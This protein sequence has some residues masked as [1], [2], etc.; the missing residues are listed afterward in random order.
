MKLISCHID[1]FGTF[2]DFDL[3]FE[4]DLNVI[5][6][7]NGWGKST[8]AAFLI[9]M[10]YGFG[11]NRKQSLKE[12]DRKH[13]LPWQG[14]KYGGTL[15]F[16]KEGKPYLLSRTFG[17]TKAGDAMCLQE[18]DT[19]R[20][21]PVENVGEWLFALDEK[22]FRR[23][24]FLGQ[25]GTPIEGAD[26][27]IHN[28]LN[29]IL[30]DSQDVRAYDA[31]MDALKERSKE[32]EKR[33]QRG[34]L[35]EL[36]GKLEEILQQ[37]KEEEA[38][39]QKVEEA[40]RSIADNKKSL[41][42]LQEEIDALK[43][44][45][46]AKEGKKK[47]AEATLKLYQE[48]TKQKKDVM[49]EL[50]TFLQKHSLP[51]EEEVQDLKEA[52]TKRKQV[53]EELLAQKE[54]R[55][56]ELLGIRKQYEELL[57][58]KKA[59]EDEERELLSFGAIPTETELLSLQESFSQQK[60]LLETLASLAKEQ[61]AKQEAL[62]LQYQGLRKEQ[63]R[64]QQEAVAASSY[65]SVELPD[66][67]KLQAIRHEC[68]EYEQLSW[69][70]EELQAK[71]KDFPASLPDASHLQH[72]QEKLSRA[73]SLSQ[74]ASGIEK[75]IAGEREEEKSLLRAIQQLDTME[76]TFPIATPAS[77]NGLAFACF[78]LG[79]LAAV[80]G[81][82]LSPLLFVATAFLFGIGLS[83]FT[84]SRK[85][86]KAFAEKKQ[87]F[88]EEKRRVEA[89]K[90][91][92]KQRQTQLAASLQQKEEE[93]KKVKHLAE[94]LRK[95]ALGELATWSPAVTEETAAAECSAL[96]EK[97]DRLASYDEQLSQLRQRKAQREQTIQSFLASYSL[98]F[99]QAKR[100]LADLE[101][102]IENASRAKQA[103]ELQNQRVLDFTGANPTLLAEGET[104]YETPAMSTIKQ[105]E[106]ECEQSI[107]D[108]LLRY[109]VKEDASSLA[110]WM[111]Q[112]KKR[113]LRQRELQEKQEQ[114]R[115]ECKA[116][117][118]EYPEL[119]DKEE[120]N[121]P[122]AVS[123]L[124][125]Q[126][127][128]LNERIQSIQTRYFIEEE[129]LET[130]ML[131][132]QTR[133]NEL[134]ELQQKK[135]AILAQVEDFEREHKAL[136]DL[137]T[138]KQDTS[139]SLQQDLKICEKRKEA[140]QKE[141][142]QA[143]S[144]ITHSDAHLQSYR[145][146]ILQ[147]KYCERELQK[148]KKSLFILKQTQAF[149]EQAKEALTSRYMGQMEANF[150][151]YLLAWLKN[152]QL[153]AFLDSKFSVKLEEDGKEHVVEG[154]SSGY[155]DMIDFCMRMALVDSL[156]EKE[157]PF[158]IMDDPFVN[159]DEEH[160]EYALRFLKGLAADSQILYFVCHPI[161]AHEP[162]EGEISIDRKQL[163]K[164][165][166]KQ[167]ETGKQAPKKEK[168]LLKP[169]LALKVL[170]SKNRITNN[171]FS[172]EFAPDSE[173]VGAAEFELFFVDEKERV[174]CDKQ[175]VTV[176]SGEVFPKKICFC[177]NTGGAVGSTYTLMVRNMAA[178]ESEVAKKIP[179]EAAL[180]FTSDFDF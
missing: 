57:S 86:E 90:A 111:E 170:T 44:E 39:I 150:N 42:S 64:L 93:A 146:L 13:Y 102:A 19:K 62:L 69:E 92:L 112:S 77:K 68:Q 2:H 117:E 29:A 120:S 71:K 75:A 116:L 138:S 61:K 46:A 166:K 17:K 8:L 130:W 172:L 51:K 27:G 106:K 110:E 15:T 65:A 60:H 79:L 143:E 156:F 132:S 152:D 177:L 82:A 114:T 167:P 80:L 4:E 89:D 56:Q 131:T 83:I 18:A 135:V 141:C 147:Q 126:E 12:N 109:S 139:F 55:Q 140:L 85:Q 28:R 7:E 163:L 52:L 6:K 37:K 33:G 26:S 107:K 178:P 11:D 1:N 66:L 125:K 100:G 23:S 87:A 25:I 43:K 38:S 174:L 94:Q 113:M 49:E 9:A 58:Q 158:L 14:G 169:A 115:K 124:L 70:E 121:V 159:L 144:D 21:L 128:R 45:I 47:E 24:A 32:Y 136:L 148:A 88:E 10:L 91:E 74:E 67:A 104:S 30:H 50:A 5:V 98:P 145:T 20:T 53:R 59:L 157:R 81:F 22:A 160:L 119:C 153:Q 34:R 63:E 165:A 155:V 35:H 176:T 149:L 3:H 129:E 179:F 108:L 105:Q 118:K 101:V 162:N 168:Y 99:A 127:K 41:L 171:L 40:R 76:E 84:N 73:R 134:A 72:I 36:Q 103:V 175:Q 173:F 31:A 151:R 48:L 137:H 95:E 54:E 161:R 133:R 97:A 142:T 122:L 164:T 123:R 154:Y 78:G 96:Q 180:T 16:E